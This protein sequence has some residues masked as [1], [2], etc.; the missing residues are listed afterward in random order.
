MYGFSNISGPFGPAC[1]YGE[2]VGDLAE[3]DAIPDKVGF[4]RASF[5]KI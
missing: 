3:I 4:H 1:V 2:H 5:P